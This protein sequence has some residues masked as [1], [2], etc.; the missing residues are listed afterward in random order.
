SERVIEA[1]LGALSDTSDG[2]RLFAAV[3]LGNLGKKSHKVLPLVVQ[4]IE[5]HEDSKFVGSGIDVLWGLVS[6]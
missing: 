6:Q 2:V 5:Q 4:W 1:L 3:A